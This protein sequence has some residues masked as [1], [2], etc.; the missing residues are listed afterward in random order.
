MPADRSS[1]PST[2]GQEPG[3]QSGISADGLS[4][5]LDSCGLAAQRTQVIQ[6]R[7]T[8]LTPACDLNGFD[9]GGVNGEGPLDADAVA[10]LPHREGLA[11]APALP[12]DD[13]AL[14]HLDPRAVALGDPHVHAKR[15]TGPERWDIRS[16]LCLLK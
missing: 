15:V 12:A 8:H 3:F 11:S 1:G 9:S 2:A 13:D 5:L 16:D 10:D 4:A 14:E 7:P 6:L